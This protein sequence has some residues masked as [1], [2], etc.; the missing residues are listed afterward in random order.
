MNQLKK[1]E[2]LFEHILTAFSRDQ[3]HKIYCQHRIQENPEIIY[4]YLVKNK[5][6]FYICGP[7][8]AVMEDVRKANEEAYVKLGGVTPEEAK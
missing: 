5:G 3:K 7:S 4:D 1:D 6:F 8:G 2:G